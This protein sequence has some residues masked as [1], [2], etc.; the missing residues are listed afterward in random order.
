MIEELQ[1]FGC[2]ITVSDYWADK[3]EVKKEYNLN[4]KNDVNYE[5]YK[6]VILAVAHD[7]FK[8]IKLENN[9]QVVYDIKSILE[10]SDGRL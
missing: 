6:A 7:K 3:N 1:D 10:K 2:D 8:S 9:K 5:D 4:L